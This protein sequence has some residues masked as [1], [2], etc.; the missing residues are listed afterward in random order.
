ML[1]TRKTSDEY[2]GYAE[3][4][5]N[6]AEKSGFEHIKA[7]FT[8]YDSPASLSMVNR[9]I[10]LTP[11]FTAKRGEKKYYFELV[12]KNPDEEDQR[13]LI[14]KWKALE[15]IARMKGGKLQLF[16]PHGS[17]KYATELV[18]DHNIEATLTKLNDI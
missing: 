12:V 2:N 7:D 10:T 14:S 18:K 3:K 8:G 4:V 11:D 16:I 13:K 1:Y 5:I 17:Y 6:Y 15:S 9:E